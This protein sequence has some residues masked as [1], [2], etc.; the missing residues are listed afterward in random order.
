MKD[1][2]HIEIG[3]MASELNNLVSLA[4]TLH[5]ALASK[6]NSNESYIGAA[7]ILF[8][9]LYDFQEKLEALSCQ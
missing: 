7:H 9:T 6:V 1:I 4:G 2:S 8:T 3:D 5:D